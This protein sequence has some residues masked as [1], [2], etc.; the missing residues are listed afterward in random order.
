MWHIATFGCAAKI[1]R[2]RAN[3]DLAGPAVGSNRRRLTPGRVKTKKKKDDEN[4]FPKSIAI[5][6][7]RE[8]STTRNNTWWNAHSTPLQRRRV[9]TQPRPLADMPTSVCRATPLHTAR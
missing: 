4:N 6:Q 8:V 2:N 3:A 1:D 7:A 9:F 5:G